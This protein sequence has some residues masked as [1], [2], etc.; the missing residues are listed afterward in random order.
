M[1]CPVCQLLL[2]SYESYFVCIT[3]FGAG[4][5]TALP[6]EGSLLLSLS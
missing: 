6:G 3:R 5:V 1:P 2:Y 4:A